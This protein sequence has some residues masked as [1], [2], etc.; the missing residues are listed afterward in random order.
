M[1]ILPAPRTYKVRDRLQSRFLLRRQ[2]DDAKKDY[3]HGRAAE[4]A[5][6]GRIGFGKMGLPICEGLTAHAFP[7]TSS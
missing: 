3:E 1:R 6:I 5:K 4:G 7:V 2:F